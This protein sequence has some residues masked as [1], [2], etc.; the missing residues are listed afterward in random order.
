MNDIPTEGIN[1][2]VLEALIKTSKK[3]QLVVATFQPINQSVPNTPV[4]RVNDS[5]F[6]TLPPRPLVY[7]AKF[8]T[9][10]RISSP[11]TNGI[12]EVINETSS[13]SSH[14]QTTVK[15]RDLSG[16]KGREAQVLEDTKIDFMPIAKAV[17]GE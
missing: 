9:L 17:I 8:H 13:D 3:L 10:E 16:P 15:Q 4:A 12:Y 2:A 14:S 1:S 5:I 7:G 11:R 6:D